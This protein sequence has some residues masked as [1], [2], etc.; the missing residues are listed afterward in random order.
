MRIDHGHLPVL[1]LDEFVHHAGAQRAGA[2]QGQH[3]DDVLEARGLEHAQVLAHARAFHL[4]D[5][6]GVAA[7]VKVVGGGVGEGQVV[8]VGRRPAL[9]GDVVQ[10]VLDEGHGLEAQEVEL[11][12]TG[13]FGHGAVELGHEFAA[14]AGV[15]GQELVHGP[16]RDHQTGGVGG[17][18]ARQALQ[19]A[20]RI[21]QLFHLRV[22]IVQLL[23]VWLGFQGLVDGHLEVVGHQL[24]DAVGLGK[25]HAQGAAHVTHHALGLHGAEGGDLGHAVLAVGVH[26]MLD[27]LG[28]AAFAEVHVD[29]G[30]G[31]AL[32]VEEALEKQIV[33]Q[34]VQVGDAQ[35]PGHQR[36]GGRTAARAHGDAV[37]LGPVDEL[38]HDEEVAGE[39]HLKDD[40]E[41]VLQ[42]VA[43]GLRV[44][45][46]AVGVL[47]QAAFQT[48][49]GQAAELGIQAG[50][51]GQL[52][53]REIVVPHVQFHVA[54]L[55]DLGRVA[56]GLG[57][58]AEHGLHLLAGLVVEVMGAEAHALGVVHG[59][60]GLDAEQHLVGVGVVGVE[61][62]AV[63]GGHDG[64]LEMVGY[65]QQALVG[66]LLL[67]QAVGLQ[68]QIEAVRVDVGVFAGQGDGA[69]HVT[70]VEGA[71]DLA[72]D[73]GRKADEAL[74]I[75]AQHG[76]VHARLVVEALQV[77]AAHQLDQI[78]VALDGL[79]EQDQVVALAGQLGGLVQMVV[80]DVDLAADDGLDAEVLAGQEELGRAEQVAVVGDGAGGHAEIL[81]AGAEILDADGAVEKAVFGVA[82]QVH[83]IGHAGTPGLGG[84]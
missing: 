21:Q 49:L 36:T 33:G 4:E 29:I 52:V 55:G 74:G 34:G 59:G 41:L 58:M 42:A 60:L 79:R 24:G 20:G 2:V 22:G 54:A 78:V 56:Q 69:V 15:E 43:V 77:A 27:D 70:G 6:V 72:R 81:G 50:A 23:E 5:A 17:G 57:Q 25:A 16:G 71:R 76:L 83:E 73:A 9:Q 28:A 44:D 12:Q 10:G 64:Q 32:G 35:R 68:L 1:A 63:V 51:F 3:G 7:G 80:A 48:F 61:V 19:T 18:M 82:V 47:F 84:R 45:A 38:L 13:F 53:D 30:Q 46:G 31:D 66:Y 37:V 65:L 62:M 67:G 39:A 26:H 14:F 40:L 8:Q 75:A 11:H